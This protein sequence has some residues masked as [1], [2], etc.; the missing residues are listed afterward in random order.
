M[1]QRATRQRAAATTKL[2]AGVEQAGGVQAGAIAASGD[3]SA[4]AVAALLHGHV[5]SSEFLSWTRCS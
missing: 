1:A 4:G 5:K 2:A 3:T